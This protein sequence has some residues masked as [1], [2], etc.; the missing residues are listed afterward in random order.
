M[1]AGTGGEETVPADG[2]T[3]ARLL[4]VDDDA[5]VLETLAEQMEEVGYSVLTASSGQTAL[6][7]L[8]SGEAADL[9]ISDLSMPGI[10]GVGLIQQVQQRRPGLP[11]ILLTGFAGNAA[12]LAIGGA[13][14]GTFSLLR[15]PVDGRQLVER[16]T[17]L[18][19]A[20]AASRPARG[21]PVAKAGR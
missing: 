15:K 3:R 14:S 19:E 12:E 13:V 10:G 4:L 8:E 9:I 16:V 11:A 17:A 7:L 5:I 21:R 2:E 6:A 18:L 1:A 20:A